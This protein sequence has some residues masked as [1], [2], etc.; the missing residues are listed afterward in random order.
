M[1]NFNASMELHCP[2]A[3]PISLNSTCKG[4]HAL[5]ARNSLEA[6]YDYSCG[7]GGGGEPM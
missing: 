2:H 5:T 7:G 3:I 6:I 4:L 1:V